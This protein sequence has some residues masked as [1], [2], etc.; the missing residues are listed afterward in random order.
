MIRRPPR[1][2]RTDTLFPYTTLFRSRLFRAED[3]SGTRQV[4]GRELHCDLVTRQNPDVMHT[5]LARDVAQ[6]YMAI[7]QLDAKSCVGKVLKNLTLHLYD[8]VFCHSL[9]ALAIPHP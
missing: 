9:P 4:I 5:H 1:S 6:N 8:V 3:N 2:T 7:F